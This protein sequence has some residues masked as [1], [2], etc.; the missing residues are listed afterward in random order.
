MVLGH[1]DVH[2]LPLSSKPADP[3]SYYDATTNKASLYVSGA[4]VL[5]CTDS[6]S[7]HKTTAQ[8]RLFPRCQGL[9]RTSYGAYE[10]LRWGGWRHACC[11]NLLRRRESSWRIVAHQAADPAA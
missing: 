2:M 1:V 8:K 9:D 10:L 7:L 3:R 11:G 5:R 6:H 4:L